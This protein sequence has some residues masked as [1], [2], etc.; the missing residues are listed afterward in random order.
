MPDQNLPAKLPDFSAE[1]Y[2]KAMIAA[3]LMPAS[4]GGSEFSRVAIDGQ[5]FVIENE[6]YPYNPKTDEPAILIRVV[7]DVRELYKMWF[8]KVGEP[9]GDL[10]AAIG[11]PDI[12]GQMCKTYD[13]DKPL[14]ARVSETDGTACASC[15]VNMMMKPENLID[16][17]DGKKCKW[18]G[19]LDF[20]LIDPESRELVSEQ[21]H[22]LPMSSTGVIEWQG[23]FSDHE[24]GYVR[25]LNFKQLLARLALTK[26][27]DTDPIAAVT[28]ATSALRLGGVIA[29]GR[30]LRAEN[31]GNRFSVPTFTPIDI[32]PVE[33]PAGLI[34]APEETSAEAAAEADAT[35]DPLPF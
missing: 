29:E 2:T 7:D 9:G 16:A 27:P 5:N 4:A 21:I 17:A 12:A 25:D 19:E 23:S 33:E 14:G 20:Q 34:A 30:I 26:F 31:K 22:T 10:A 6:T 13:H 18:S 28:K 32:I 3:G 24:R 15:A 1:D 35:A 8:P 11:R